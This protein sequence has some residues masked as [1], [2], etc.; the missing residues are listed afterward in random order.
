MFLNLEF[1]VSQLQAGTYFMKISK[2]N[3][4]TIKR[5]LIGQ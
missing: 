3:L 2:D 1:N 5:F 4:V